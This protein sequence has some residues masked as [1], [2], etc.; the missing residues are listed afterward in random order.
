MEGTSGR[1]QRVR[2]TTGLGFM[3]NSFRTLTVQLKTKPAHLLH[4]VTKDP[5]TPTSSTCSS[6]LIQSHTPTPIKEKKTSLVLSNL[7]F[8]PVFSPAAGRFTCPPVDPPS[9]HSLFKLPPTTS[10]P[11]EVNSQDGLRAD[12]TRLRLTPSSLSVWIYISLSSNSRTTHKST[13]CVLNSAAV[14]TLYI[15]DVA[16]LFHSIFTFSML[17]AVLLLL[18][19]VVLDVTSRTQTLTCSSSDVFSPA[20]TRVPGW[21]YC[22]I[23]HAHF[24]LGLFLAALPLAALPTCRCCISD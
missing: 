9:L 10:L 14:H 7:N 12:W 15:T 2:R 23:S 5:D 22:R 3:D 21:C 19:K 20:P 6:R 24:S 8:Y 18:M 1:Q 16:H 11:D 13:T 4:G 17:C